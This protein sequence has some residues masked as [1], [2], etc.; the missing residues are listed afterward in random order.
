MDELVP[1][2]EMPPIAIGVACN[3][4]QQP[5]FWRS[6][7]G[8]EWNGGAL[9]S[10]SGALTDQN[11]NNI[12]HW[13]LF[14]TGLEWLFFVDDDIELPPDALR[15]L[16]T[17]AQRYQAWYVTGVYYRRSV[18]YEPLIFRQE[19]DGWYRSLLP[20][21]DYAV[22]DVIPVDA[23]GLGCTLIH[24]RAFLSIIDHHFIAR[25]FNRSFALVPFAQVYENERVD[26]KPGVYLGRDRAY[27]VQEIWPQRMGDL[28]EGATI[29]FFAFE[30]GRTEDLYFCELLRQA[31]VTMYAHTGVEV[32]HWGDVPFDRNAFLHMQ[33]VLKEQSREQ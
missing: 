28:E 30:Y 25:R 19:P 12:A 5:P 2:A 29:P 9:M 13:F 16:Y 20:G 6:L 32:K 26:L 3:K 11:R 23:S 18:P 27:L 4:Y 17:T 22:G 8:I 15:R 14:D 21:Q 1:I 7:W 33:N 10:S 31:G 24:R